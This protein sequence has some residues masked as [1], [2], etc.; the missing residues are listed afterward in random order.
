MSSVDR[1]LESTQ[2]TVGMTLS[3][4]QHLVLN[5]LTLSVSIF[6]PYLYLLIISIQYV[7]NII[8]FS[9]IPYFFCDIFIYYTYIVPRFTLER[10]FA[11]HGDLLVGHG[12][13]EGDLLGMEVESSVD[14]AIES[15]TSNRSVEPIGVC[16][17]ESKLVGT[18]RVR[19]Q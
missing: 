2:Q 9:E 1:T 13:G 12:V 4:L 14:L 6:Y 19:S 10:S 15:V 8:K 7:P 17:V 3:P 11:R 18:T 5:G 16:A